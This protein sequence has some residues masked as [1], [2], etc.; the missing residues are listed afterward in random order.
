MAIKFQMHAVINTDTGAKARIGLYE[1]TLGDG[2]K[3]ISIYA[4]DYRSGL[5]GILPNVRNDSDS[6]TDYFETDRAQIVEGEELYPAA[7]AA[8]QAR[9]AAWEARQAKKAAKRAAR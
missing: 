3:A 9:T 8:C 5:A 6:M 1:T 2:R 7:L 4:K